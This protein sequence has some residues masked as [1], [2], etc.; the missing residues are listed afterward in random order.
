M[1]DWN[2]KNLID[3]IFSGTGFSDPAEDSTKKLSNEE[4][5]NTYISETIKRLGLPM[6][7]YGAFQ[8]FSD[9][10]AEI[11]SN[12]NTKAKNK[13]TTAT[14]AFQ[15]VKGSVLPALNRMARF[16]DLE[17][18]A[19][20]LRNEY[21]EGNITDEQHRKLI[22]DLSYG[23]QESMFLADIFEKTIDRPGYGDYLL[24]KVTQGDVEAMKELYYKGH[25][26]NPD[27][28]TINRTNQ[29]F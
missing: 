20:K 7:T 10:V 14:G 1:S 2:L 22:S 4:M 17:P 26:T 13:N 25:H 24:R 27:E 29:I 19:E 3:R 8:N 18:W 15:F 5:Q 6:Q 12:S 23:Q 28:A 21:L 11:E 16:G 9:K